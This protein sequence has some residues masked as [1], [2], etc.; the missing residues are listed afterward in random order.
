MREWE[1]E[2]RGNFFGVKC[3]TMVGIE[4]DVVD[5][6]MTHFLREEK[7]KWITSIQMLSVIETRIMNCLVP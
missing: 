1:W 5:A 3:C 4:D 6:V 2:K 7:R